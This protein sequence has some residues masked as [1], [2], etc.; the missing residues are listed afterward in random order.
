[1]VLAFGLDHIIISAD[2]PKDPGASRYLENTAS[3]RGK[4]S[5][6]AEAGRSGPVE[7]ADVKLLVDGV[8]REMGY[9]KMTALTAAPVANPVWVEKVVTVASDRDGVFR[10][11]VNRDAHVVKG[12]KIGTIT[13]YL[14]QPLQDVTA[15]ETGIILFVR[16]VP[17]LKKGDTLANVGV[18]KK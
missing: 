11:I 10:P 18:I 6:T 16:A 12:A 3:T 8:L 1:M 7:A 9:L 15:P 2:R 17:S 14:D 5:F 13:D 4:P